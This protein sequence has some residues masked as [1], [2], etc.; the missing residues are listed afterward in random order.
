M[1][2]KLVAYILA[3]ILIGKVFSKRLEFVMISV[4]INPQFSQES[5]T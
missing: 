5:A 4:K 3:L 1:L 2:N